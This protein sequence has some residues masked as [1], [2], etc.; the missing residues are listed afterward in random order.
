MSD[1]TM[2]GS[3][4]SAISSMPD[5]EA[6]EVERGVALPQP[7]QRA[8]DGRFEARKADGVKEI[9]PK[10]AAAPVDAAKEA[11]EAKEAQ[12]AEEVKL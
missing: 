2:D 9:E 1:E 6:L 10:D 4:A 11:K 12:P 7:T 3:I 5:I 8:P